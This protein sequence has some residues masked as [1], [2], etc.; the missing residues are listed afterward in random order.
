MKYKYIF[1]GGYTVSG[2]SA[3]RDLLK[4]YSGIQSTN[5][6][7]RLIVDPDG[8]LNIYSSVKNYNPYN[9]DLAIKRYL[10]MVNSMSKKYSKTYFGINHNQTFGN[11]FVRNSNHFI[12][13]ITAN[14]FNGYWYGIKS[15]RAIIFN[16]LYKKLNIKSSQKFAP[17]IYQFDSNKNIKNEI[18]VYVNQLFGNLTNLNDSILVDEPF[19]SL[20]S[21]DIT[22]LINNSAVIMVERDPRDIYCTILEKKYDFVPSNINAFIQRYKTIYQIKDS[23]VTEQTNSLRIQFEDLVIN[24]EYE[25]EKITD[26]LGLKHSKHINKKKVFLSR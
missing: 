21:N 5:K 18:N 23:N 1:I 16:Y 20:C 7:I 9:F 11:N 10:K 2:S 3:V 24:Y 8:L 25:L 12:E 6:E 22:S 19:S 15:Y 17:I 13:C 4:E 14:N 26:F